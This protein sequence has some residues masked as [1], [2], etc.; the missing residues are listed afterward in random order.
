MENT[1]IL[2]VEDQGIVADD[3]RRRL[4]RLGY[5]VPDIAFSGEEAVEK[6][7]TFHPDL[8]LM[9]IRLK[10]DMDGV[11]A[12]EKIHGTLDI[13]IIYLTA[14]SD[15]ETLSRA[16]KTE[17]FGYIL[18]KPFDE[19]EL[20]SNIEM[21]L[22]KHQMEKKRGRLITKLKKAMAEI[23]VY[24]KLLPICASCKKIR[25]E[26]GRWHQIESYIRDHSDVEFSHGVCPECT[27]RLYGDI[28]GD[29]D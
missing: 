29:D 15:R 9:D 20:L 18:K 11:E 13:P 17:P 26:E 28:L 19:R 23:K 5:T 16:K 25:D 4:T 10:G 21:A 3:L 1:Q 8:I 24:R 14:H 2:V 6:A 12:A 27:Q 22:Y 7:K